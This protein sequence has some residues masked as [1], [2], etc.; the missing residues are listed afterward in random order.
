MSV[1]TEITSHYYVLDENS[2]SDIERMARQHFSNVGAA[3]LVHTH[4]KWSSPLQRMRTA[5]NE[6]C[7][8]IATDQR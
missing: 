3:S 8:T 5:C 4:S 1:E 6:S 2:R 7:K